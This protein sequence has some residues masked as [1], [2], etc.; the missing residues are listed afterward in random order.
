MAKPLYHGGQDRGFSM[1]PGSKSTSKPGSRELA[2]KANAAARLEGET[3]SGSSRSRSV[4]VGKRHEPGGDGIEGALWEL[5]PSLSSAITGEIAGELW[6]SFSRS[7]GSYIVVSRGYTLNTHAAPDKD[8]WESDIGDIIGVAVV[9][10][11]VVPA[12]IGMRGRS[13]G[14]CPSL[15]APFP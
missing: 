5:S 13:C 6:L 8:D 10:T 1:S 9:A 14:Q 11:A 4:D 2:G 7:L 12:A 15:V 3:L